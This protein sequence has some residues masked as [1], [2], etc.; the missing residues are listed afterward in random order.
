M[1]VEIIGIFA[2]ENQVGFKLSWCD[3]I[4]GFGEILFT[5]NGSMFE[6]VIDSENMGKDFVKE[7][8]VALVDKAR[9]AR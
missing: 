2:N 7:V 8:L 3:T 9:L 5:R 6:I 4:E 1:D